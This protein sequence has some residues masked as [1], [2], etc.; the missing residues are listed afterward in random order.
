VQKKYNIRSYPGL[1][2]SN[3][4]TLVILGCSAKRKC[5]ERDDSTDGFSR[6]S[7]DI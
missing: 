2:F 5:N 3:S 7:S 4:R 6:R 1:E